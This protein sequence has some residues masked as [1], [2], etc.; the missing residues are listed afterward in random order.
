MRRLAE[1]ERAEAGDVPERQLVLRRNAAHH[2]QVRE[3]AGVEAAA[4]YQCVMVVA[5]DR[6]V[7]GLDEAFEVGFVGGHLECWLSRRWGRD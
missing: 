6:R 4:F 2:L 5:E 7:A 1:V 3:V